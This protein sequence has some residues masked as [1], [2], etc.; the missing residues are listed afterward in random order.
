[1]TTTVRATEPDTSAATRRHAAPRGRL[2]IVAVAMC[3]VAAHAVDA[4]LVETVGGASAGLRLARAA[5]IGGG[6]ALSLL[7]WRRERLR[8]W[9][10]L[11][12]GTAGLIEGLAVTGARA[13]DGVSG[14][15]ITGWLSLVASLTLLG[16]WWA[17]TVR[18]RPWWRPVLGIVGTLLV[19]DL[20]VYPV[21]VG[22]VTANAMRPRLGAGTPSDVGLHATTVTIAS[23]DGTRLAAWYVPSRSGAAVLLLPGSGST[24]DDVLPHAAMLARHGFGV[25]MLDPR[26]HGG[27]EGE[28]MEFGWGANADLSAAVD[29]LTD[30]PDVDASRIGALGL[31]MGGEQAVTAA[32]SD[33]RIRAVVADGASA[34][35]FEDVRNAPE[36]AG[37]GLSVA[38]T[39]LEMQVADLLADASPPLALEDCLRRV[40]PRPV[41]LVAGSPTPESGAA[42]AYEGLEG[43]SVSVWRIADA[44][45]VSGLSLHPAA[46]DRHV[47]GF[48]SRALA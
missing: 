26:G 24:R 3:V 38:W 7:A 39:W 8:L 33:A 5:A 23:A 10:M 34:R 44:P 32:A 31:S 9:L 35:T 13:R 21:A 11:L 19:V 15:E 36:I 47:A 12:V 43:G 30:R 46:Y 42:D 14:N 28:P 40:A 37:G 6:V 27:S 1:M 2:S 45:H 20:V 17:R 48:L 18:F 29:F 22:V 4:W 41:L 25:L 16:A